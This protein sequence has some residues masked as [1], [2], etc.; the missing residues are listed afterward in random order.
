MA[1]SKAVRSTTPRSRQTRVSFPGVVKLTTKPV[2]SPLVLA[3]STPMVTLS[4]STFPQPGCC[5]LIKSTTSLASPTARRMSTRTALCWHSR[6]KCRAVSVTISSLFLKS[7]T[8]IKTMSTKWK[9]SFVALSSKMS[10]PNMPTP[11]ASSKMLATCVMRPAMGANSLTSANAEASASPRVDFFAVISVSSSES[12]V[13]YLP[14]SSLSTNLPHNLLAACCKSSEDM[15]AHI[16][17]RHGLATTKMLRS[18]T[19]TW[20]KALPSMKLA[21]T[22]LPSTFSRAIASPRSLKT[23]NLVWSGFLHGFTING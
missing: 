6:N 10:K 21:T 9:L 5:A 2:L 19:W 11:K 14:S 18:M 17:G 4:G 16:R 8:G 13:R 3:E 15:S 7:E 22:L 1:C 23:I 20:Y 12:K